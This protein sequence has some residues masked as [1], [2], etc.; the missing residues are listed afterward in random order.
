MKEKLFSKD[1]WRAILLAIGLLIVGEAILGWQYNRLE[2]KRIPQ[3][4]AQ[5]VSQQ[6]E[7]ARQSATEVLRTFLDARVARNEAKAR[8]LFTEQAVEQEKEGLFSLL[9][10][11]ASYQIEGSDAVSEGAYRFEVLLLG[12]NGSFPT[13][14]II[15]V[16]KIL[17]SY[18]IDSVVVGG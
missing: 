6:Q 14:E 7:L 8:A 15:L 12:P 10:Q 13:P 18:Y 17:D 3:L 16:K 11:Y 9:G 4:E 2:Q 5:V 1:A